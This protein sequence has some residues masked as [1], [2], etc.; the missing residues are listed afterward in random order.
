MVLASPSGGHEVRHE[1][2]NLS[3]YIG[4]LP[5]INFPSAIVRTGSPPGPWISDE[6]TALSFGRQHRTRTLRKF[7]LNVVVANRTENT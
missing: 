7:Y 3:T 4:K 2:T 5:M 1:P 6:Q